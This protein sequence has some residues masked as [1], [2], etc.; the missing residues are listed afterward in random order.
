MTMMTAS[1]S[2]FDDVAAIAA[3]LGALSLSLFLFP[4]F[5]LSLSHFLSYFTLRWP[6][7][8]VSGLHFYSFAQTMLNFSVCCCNNY[9]SSNNSSNISSNVC[10]R[11]TSPTSSSASSLASP[12]TSAHT[13]C[14]LFHFIAWLQ[15]YAKQFYLF[16]FV[17]FCSV[18]FAGKCFTPEKSWLSQRLHSWGYLTIPS[19]GRQG[20]RE[21]VKEWTCKKCKVEVPIN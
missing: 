3:I 15:F 2:A 6:G 18:L 21:Q 4:S 20:V 19:N 10:Q 17:S 8:F 9:S 5:S 11:Q 16:C 13:L 7:A 1:V 12:S 14:K